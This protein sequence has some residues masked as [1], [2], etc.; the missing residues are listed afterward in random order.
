LLK[1]EDFDDDSHKHRREM[2]GVVVDV[3]CEGTSLSGLT[4]ALLIDVVAA[5]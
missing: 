3:F 5:Q 4:R 1:E 2:T